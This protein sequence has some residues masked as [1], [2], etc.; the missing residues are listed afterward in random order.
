LA[1]EAAKPVQKSSGECAI[2]LV[3]D[4]DLVRESVEA[5]IGKLGYRVTAVGS[6]RDALAAL[7][8]DS[9][10]DLLFTDVIMPGA[11]TGVDLACEVMKRWPEIKVLATSGYTESNLLGKVKI[12]EGIVL[13]PKPYS[14]TALAQALAS[15]V[16]MA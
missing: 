11:M 8:E 14:T 4:D 15:A 6:A 2:L 3:E 10:Y 16:G 7:E 5:K 9:D 12:P 13:L 1:T